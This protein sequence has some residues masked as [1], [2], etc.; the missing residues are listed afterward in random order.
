MLR[1]CERS[2]SDPRE[3]ARNRSPRRTRPRETAPRE[4]HP[5]KPGSQPQPQA[6]GDL[7]AQ[8]T[9]GRDAENGLCFDARVTDGEGRLYLELK[10][11]RTSPL[12]YPVA[13]EL[14]RP[15]QKLVDG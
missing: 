8:V 14:R 9:P 7:Y 13:E 2:G 12:P 6:A 4:S 15:L 5:G 10:D 3:H 11:Y 1:E